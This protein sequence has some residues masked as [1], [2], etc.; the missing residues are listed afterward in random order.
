M[1]R[2][3]YS[4]HSA[5]NT[6]HQCTPHWTVQF[7]LQCTLQYT[8]QCTMDTWQITIA[9]F[10]LTTVSS[11]LLPCTSMHCL[12]IYILD[13]KIDSKQLH[14]TAY[15]HCTIQSFKFR[16]L[17]FFTPFPILWWHRIDHYQLTMILNNIVQ[18]AKRTYVEGDD[19]LICSFWRIWST[20]K[21]CILWCWWL[22]MM[23]EG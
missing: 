13:G 15:I 1:H 12:L 6:T 14:C 3:L 20:K 19:D 2:T 17:T 7:I 11:S 8:L 18:W 21:I 9:H 5:K 4:V 10:P 22:F 16:L 23:L